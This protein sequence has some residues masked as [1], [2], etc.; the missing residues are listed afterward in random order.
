MK[1]F[2]D[3][4]V[5]GYYLDYHPASHFWPLQL[6]GTGIVLTV[7]AAAVGTAF[8]LLRRGTRAAA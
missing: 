8:W 3:H 4:G 7:A 5:T 2:T 6:I 1:C